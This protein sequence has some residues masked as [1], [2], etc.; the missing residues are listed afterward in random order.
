MKTSRTLIQ[1]TALVVTTA[2]AVLLAMPGMASAAGATSAHAK[3]AAAKAAAPVRPALN[4]AAQGVFTNPNTP[5]YWGAAGLIDSTTFTAA[6]YGPDGQPGSAIPVP[7][8]TQW[9]EPGGATVWYAPASYAYAAKAK[10]APNTPP[11]GPS[12]C[13]AAVGWM[14]AGDPTPGQIAIISMAALKVSYASGQPY[15][16]DGLSTQASRPNELVITVTSRATSRL[17]QVDGTAD[18][19]YALYSG[20]EIALLDTMPDEDLLSMTMHELMLSRSLYEST[21]DVGGMLGH[22]VP[23]LSAYPVQDVNMLTASGCR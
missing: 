14:L 13:T 22:V 17:L 9:V 8:D 23:L 18:L 5:V 2:A 4:P 11:P 1:R 12:R 16:Y 6:Y 7:G 20:T 15:R 10:R 21:P 3:A 19:G